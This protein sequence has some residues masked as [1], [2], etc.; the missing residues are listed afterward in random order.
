MSRKS[1]TPITLDETQAALD[2]L[3]ANMSEDFVSPVKAIAPSAAQLLLNNGI[4]K[5]SSRVS[6]LLKRLVEAGCIEPIKGSR[7]Y[8]VLRSTVLVGRE[9]VMARGLQESFEKTI[10]LLDAQNQQL[11]EQ[12]SDIKHVHTAAMAQQQLKINEL[13]EHL[14]V[15]KHTIRNLEAERTTLQNEL[16][17]VGE[18]VNP[19]GDVRQI[20]ERMLNG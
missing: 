15:A 13:T 6:H 10:R 3:N 18:P 11:T 4:A 16:T 20:M 1:P 19:S 17:K 2:V 9:P 7:S 12:L 5:T 8:R 14:R